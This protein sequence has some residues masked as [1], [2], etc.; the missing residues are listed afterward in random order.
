MTKR[1]TH[2]YF[3]K[4]L[5]YFTPVAFAGGIYLLILKEPVWCAVAILLGVMIL[6]TK[7]VTEISLSDKK[8]Q[9]YLSFLGLKLNNDHN[10][11]NSV[12]RIVVTKGHFSQK[13]VPPRG[14]DR[15]IKWSTL[16]ATLIFDN[17][18][19][20]LL[21][22]SGKKKHLLELKETTEFLQIGVEDRTT[23]QHYWIDMEKV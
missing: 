11:F 8:Y 22:T 2:S 10:K 16:I 20:D 17:D 7:Y 18:T 5:K 13:I 19:L 15:T 21:S 6:T 3:P 14:P 23:V 1:I 9:D 12:D 4:E